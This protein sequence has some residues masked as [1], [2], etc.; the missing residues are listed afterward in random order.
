[1][2][3]PRLS[4]FQR[5]IL[6][7]RHYRH[8]QVRGLSGHPMATNR[9][10]SAKSKRKRRQCLTPPRG[11]WQ[12]HS[13]SQLERTRNRMA[14]AQMPIRR[15][16]QSGS[17]VRNRHAVSNGLQA[18]RALSTKIW[19]RLS[20][21]PPAQGLGVYDRESVRLRDRIPSIFRAASA[22]EPPSP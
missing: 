2:D 10:P 5:G 15:N 9:P 16:R 19:K 13:T 17:T 18:T 7:I 21:R 11:F 3:F 20:T 12:S 1:L 22:I 6:L 8:P 14:G 4:Q